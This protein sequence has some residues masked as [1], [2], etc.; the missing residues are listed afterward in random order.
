MTNGFP[1]AWKLSFRESQML[2]A[3]AGSPLVLRS[4]MEAISMRGHSG[5]FG[6]PL[7]VHLFYL[8]EKLEPFGIKIKTTRQ[9]GY[10]LSEG[11]ETVA[12]YMPR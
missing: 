6:R 11:R 1:S 4:E 3:L 10:K 5:K 7:K 9:L 8:R 2:R 12:Q